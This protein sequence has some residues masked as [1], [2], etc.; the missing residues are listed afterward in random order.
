MENKWIK[1]P[2][3]AWWVVLLLLGFSCSK[4]M[5]LTELLPVEK[6]VTRQ[7]AEHRKQRI[8]QLS[9]R[10]HFHL[11]A[12]QDSPVTAT[13]TILFE[14]RD[15]KSPLQLDFKE[16][17]SKLHS[18]KVNNRKVALD[19]R[20]EHLVIPARYLKAGR[21]RV[22]LDFTAGNLSL[23][24]NPDYLY[25]LL[26]PDRARTLF[27]VFDQPNL[28]ASFTLS[29]TVPAGWKA[30]ANA[31]VQD[32]LP[33]AG[34]MTYHFA[35]SDTIPPYLFSFVAGRFQRLQRQVAGRPMMLLHRETEA[36]RL[37][38]NLAPLFRL[39]DQALAFLQ[40][41]TG[42]PYPFRKFD[43]VALPDFQYAG[44]EHVGL[45]DYKAATLLPDTGATQDQVLARA[46]LVAHETAHMWFGNLV[47]M[48][49]FEDVWMKEVFANFMADKITRQEAANAAYDH[50]FL[51]DHFPAA[52][53]VDRT[54]GARP[55]RQPLDNLQEAGTLYGPI[56]YHKAP[57]MMRQLET[58]MG[59]AAFQ[60][61][62]QQY[63]ATYAH[64]NAS[65]P[66]LI[67]ILDALSPADLQAWNQVW[68]NEPGRPVFDYQL[69][70]AGGR[71]SRLVVS[72]QAEDKSGKLWPQAFELLLVSPKGRRKITVQMN[73]RQ[74]EVQE[75]AGE[76]A[77]SFIL[78]NSSGQGYGVFPVDPAL[79]GQV[80][81]LAEPLARATAY[82]SLYENMLN[83]RGIKPRQ[84][85]NA[86]RR[87]LGRET[88]ELNLKLLT[89]QLRDIY[90]KFLPAAARTALAPSLEKELW[91]AMRQAPSPNTRKLLLQTYQGIALTKEAQYSLYRIWSKQQ[92]P[93]GIVLS[94]DD[95]TDL[96]LAL[97]VR[98]YATE[99]DILQRQL[100]RIRNADRRQRLAFLQPALSPDEQRRD[101]FFAS[102][103]EAG[104]R[105][106]EAW[107]VSALTYLHHPLRT[108][109]SGK[110]LAQTLE[111]LPEIQ[112][113]GDIFFPYNWLRS[114]LGAYQ[115]AQAAQVVQTYLQTHPQVPPRLQAQVRQAADDLLRARKLLAAQP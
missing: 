95:Y 2:G 100:G 90:W 38:R 96:A 40:D 36:A 34:G 1:R 91:D 16:Q 64:G 44:M 88:N 46:S 115:S 77:P 113:T 6:G 106:K 70:V 60:K 33:G 102:L 45:I 41:Y 99:N 101:A 20:Q 27:P 29:L 65:W 84:L 87:G 62:L 51:I 23:N 12:Q 58:L 32:S 81:A 28:K 47:T 19:H 107:V 93:A 42:I 30:A 110:Y 26:V 17:S 103:R 21:N 10:L 104:N 55:I 69:E 52:Y 53:S 13:E 37:Q 5:N 24:R 7:L 8:S 112:Q 35:P 48:D 15:N 98:D 61:G 4:K 71:I 97:A 75:A 39:H 67:G 111:L 78:F 56:I 86:Y 54:A 109:T 3:P 18:L 11:P 114:S 108:A 66:Q 83:G 79:P 63:L 92:P 50:K 76:P 105:E 94:E 22:D 82:I 73:D 31:P 49:W 74:V 59:A 43:F 68:V 14:L 57:I 85:L 89:G 25:T 80:F 9:Y 72:Q